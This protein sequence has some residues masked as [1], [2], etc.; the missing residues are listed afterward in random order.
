[1]SSSTGL[2]GI[3]NTKSI[4]GPEI[5][6]NTEMWVTINNLVHVDPLK[7]TKPILI[8]KWKLR[9]EDNPW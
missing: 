3:L 2:T 9:H 1:M 4:E 7:A 8:N 6:N 5:Y